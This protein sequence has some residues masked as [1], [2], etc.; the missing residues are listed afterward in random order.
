[1]TARLT[2]LLIWAAVLAGAVAWGLP[3]FTRGTPVP[4]GASLA[5]PAPP[6]GGG[7]VRLLGQPPAVPVAQAPVVAVESR[8]QLLGVVAP[9]PGVASGLALIAVDGKPARALAVGRE[10]EP[11]LRLLTVGHR[12]VELGAA[13]GAPSVTLSLPPLAEAQ[14]G[15]PGEMAAAQPSLGLPGQAQPSLGLAGQAQ[16][17]VPRPA[18]MVVPGMVPGTGYPAVSGMRLPPQLQQQ[19]QQL[20]RGTPVPVP[21]ADA[22]PA[23]LPYQP[24]GNG[25]PA[26]VPEGQPNPSGNVQMR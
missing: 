26:P 19:L 23:S 24:E 21:Q 10:L 12:Q 1:M 9:R 20:Q 4:A 16:T 18:Q 17:A 14:R 8:F 25:T 2:T 6:A 11:G 22:T 5:V 7:L 13:A 15:R 3:L